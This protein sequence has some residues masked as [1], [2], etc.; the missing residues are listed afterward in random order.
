MKNNAAVYYNRKIG[1]KTMRNIGIIVNTDNVQA[2]ILCSYLSADLAKKNI[3]SWC[4]KDLI[5]DSATTDLLLVLGGDGT[6]LR[7]FQNYGH[8]QIPFLCVN[9]GTVGFLSSLEPDE[10]SEYWQKIIDGNYRLDERS[11][12]SVIIKRKDY[13][14]ISLYALN[15]VVIRTTNLHVSRQILKVDNKELFVYSGDGLIIATSTGSTGYALSTGGAIV[16]PRIGCMVV[17]PICSR[18]ASLKTII[19]SLDHNL[20]VISK[21]RKPSTIFTD[22]IELTDINIDDSI[23]VRRADIQAKFVSLKPDRYFNLLSMH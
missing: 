7:A 14:D 23:I 9:F 18:D 11:V 8:L 19:F 1:N 6:M 20:E 3:A 12:L 4:E 2:E 5:K 16:D 10:L 13:E 21:D 22:G 17:S 15:E